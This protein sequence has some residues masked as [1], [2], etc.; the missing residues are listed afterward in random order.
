MGGGL[1]KN[2]LMWVLLEIAL[3]QLNLPGCTSKREPILALR[4]PL[5]KKKRH[6]IAV[7]KSKNIW[8]GIMLR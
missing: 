5:K 1:G 2:G 8:H 6:E 7:Q 3:G 4:V